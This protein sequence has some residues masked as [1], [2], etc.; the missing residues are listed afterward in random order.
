M[1]GGCCSVAS[2]LRAG[3]TIGLVM[4]ACVHSA[5]PTPPTPAVQR[6]MLPNGLH[7]VLIRDRDAMIAWGVTAGDLNEDDRATGVA[8]VLPRALAIGT[9]VQRANIWVGPDVSM[10]QLTHVDDLLEGLA[11]LRA[12]LRASIDPEHVERVLANN[13]VRHDDDPVSNA[14]FSGLRLAHHRGTA[15]APSEL[16]VEDFETYRERW[17]VAHRMTI[18]V[19]GPWPFD[20]AL[21]AIER[22]L[23]DVPDRATPTTPA[24][25]EGPP[26]L[27]VALGTRS[28]V[29]IGFRSSQPVP[30][31]PAELRAAVARWLFEVALATRLRLT[32][33]HDA[34]IDVAEHRLSGALVAIEVGFDASTDKAEA[35]RSLARE[36]ARSHTTPFTR[37]ELAA[38]RRVPANA[39]SNPI[40]GP[41]LGTECISEAQRAVLGFLF[42]DCHD[43]DREWHRL[44]PVIT[45][46]E[47][48]HY[49]TI[50]DVHSATF[51]VSDRNVVP[52]REEVQAALE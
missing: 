2:T 37:E 16:R 29:V 46:A 4:L 44:I 36:L 38:A 25:V 15:D 31:T 41:G 28:G 17:Y 45:D 32:L 23:G 27:Q 24:L 22:I 30:S 1:S 14:R 33:E 13:R 9:S 49:R 6:G 47:I 35:A 48:D 12:W 50:L 8:A 21:P 52:T 19:A 42:P 7:Y 34:R 5:P 10:L 43:E 26:V 3:L 18:V 20:E 39:G 51:A 11:S 40:D